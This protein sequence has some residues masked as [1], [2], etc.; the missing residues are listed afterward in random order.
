MVLAPQDEEIS[1]VK[2]DKPLLIGIGNQFD[3]P[4]ARLYRCFI[5]SSLRNGFP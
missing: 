1:M 2:A 4:E 3:G 5:G